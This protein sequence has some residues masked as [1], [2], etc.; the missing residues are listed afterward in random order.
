MQQYFSIEAGHR[1]CKLH[2]L[3]V[4]PIGRPTR[5]RKIGGKLAGVS[6]QTSEPVRLW[7]GEFDDSV[8]PAR[9]IGEGLE[10][11]ASIS[12]PAIMHDG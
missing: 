10:A 5:A 2:L 3:G 1:Y 11:E 12:G 6:F 9:G 4:V 7:L 8:I